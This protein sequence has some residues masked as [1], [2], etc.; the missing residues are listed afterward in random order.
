MRKATAEIVVGIL[1]IVLAVYFFV[2]ASQLPPSL[3]P[4]DV[5]SA[6]FPTLIIIAMIIFSLALVANAVKKLNKKDDEKIELK[7]G[8][9]ILLSV[10]ILIIYSA[11]IPLIGYYV[12]TTVCL[13]AFLLSAG[14]RSWRNI[15]YTVV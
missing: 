15:M 7:R 6:A 11:L 3:N 4:M 10:V 13:I 9:S 5:G 14:E 2:E 1:L 12:S 8:K